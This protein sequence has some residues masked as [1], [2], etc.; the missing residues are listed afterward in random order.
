MVK[1]PRAITHEALVHGQPCEAPLRRFRADVLEP[2]AGG[3]CLGATLVQLAPRFDRSPAHLQAL[4]EVLAAIEG[5]GDVAVE[6]RNASWLVPAEE[7][8][9]A[10]LR[11]TRPTCSP[12]MRPH[13]ASSTGPR[14]RR[15]RPLM[16]ATPMSASTDGAPKRGPRFPRGRV[17]PV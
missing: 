4:H 3:D 9:L 16:R 14:F 5:I 10:P 2:L 13:C 1:A 8:R 11:R 7:G 17:G 12:R 15:S 6:F